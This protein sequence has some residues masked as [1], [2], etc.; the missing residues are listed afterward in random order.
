M[1]DHVPFVAHEAF[2]PGEP[3]NTE[4]A[5]RARFAPEEEMT[6]VMARDVGL[7]CET[8]HCDHAGNHDEAAGR[9]D[10]ISFAL[11]PR[12]ELC[13]GRFVEQKNADVRKREIHERREYVMDHAQYQI[14]VC[15][16]AAAWIERRKTRHAQSADASH[17]SGDRLM[18]IAASG[19]G[20][21]CRN[22]AEAADVKVAHGR[23][24]VIADG[25]LQQGMGQVAVYEERGQDGSGGESDR[26]C[27]RKQTHHP[28][29]RVIR[30][31]DRIG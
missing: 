3:C 8:G 14:P 30:E 1:A 9:V 12:D 16:P 4:G 23:V 10:A 27:Q 20:E 7:D 5:E 24:V 29:H 18:Q 25:A 13:P 19:A 26:Q 17:V 2:A 28:P 22:D 31:L 6:G 15:I 11:M 21:K